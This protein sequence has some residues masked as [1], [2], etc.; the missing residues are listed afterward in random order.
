MY[1]PLTNMK[2][3]SEGASRLNAY[4]LEKTQPYP[5]M[6]ISRPVIGTEQGGLS[7]SAGSSFTSH[8]VPYYGD[9]KK[10]ATRSLEKI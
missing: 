2:Y 9:I 1:M 5:E 8:F 6:I 10:P 4:D 7:G 3:R